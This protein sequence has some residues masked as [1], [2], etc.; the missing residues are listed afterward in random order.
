MS[1]STTSGQGQRGPVR[2]RRIWGRI[3][4]T[5]AVVLLFGIVGSFYYL[6]TTTPIEIVATG[7]MV[8]TL[9]VGDVVLLERLRRP[10]RVGD[11]VEAPVPLLVQ[12]QFHYPPAVTHRI[13]KIKNGRIT[14]KGDANSSPD[15]FDVPISSVHRRLVTVVPWA[16]RILGFISSPFGL[17]WLVFGGILLF[18]PALLEVLR[19]PIPEGPNIGDSLALQELIAAVNDYGVHL[20]THTAILHDMADASRQLSSVATRLEASFGLSADD[21]TSAESGASALSPPAPES[22]PEPEPEPETGIW[23]DCAD[24]FDVGVAALAGFAL[25][26]GNVA[27]PEAFVTADGFP[28]GLWLSE[29][30]DVLRSGEYPAARRALL[31]ELGVQPKPRRFRGPRRLR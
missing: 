17:I 31:G 12:Q 27:V 14:T 3:G 6:G 4:S 20:K 23:E 11:I 8:P 10:P 13:V 1:S 21:Q 5:L 26:Q 24:L 28:L 19:G 22:E 25:A 18:G 30:R 2:R 16:G 29:Q 15:P 9:H 7:S